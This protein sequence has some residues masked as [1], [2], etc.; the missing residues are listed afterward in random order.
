[1]KI[2]SPHKKA[3]VTITLVN[4]VVNQSSADCISANFPYT[5]GSIESFLTDHLNI[6]KNVPSWK[7]TDFQSFSDA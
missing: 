3:P 2:E 1:M 4:G 7:S 6:S 5:T